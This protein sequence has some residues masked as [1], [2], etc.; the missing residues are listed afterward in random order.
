VRDL[1]HY[2]C[3]LGALIDRL[4]ARSDVDPS[5]GER[6]SKAPKGSRR[7]REFCMQDDLLRVAKTR[8]LQPLFGFLDVIDDEFDVALVPEVVSKKPRMFTLSLAIKV[9]I[10]ASVPGR[11]SQ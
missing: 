8:I 4:I 3:F 9:A 10:C 11:F 1:Q 2:T 5:R 6:S 7:I